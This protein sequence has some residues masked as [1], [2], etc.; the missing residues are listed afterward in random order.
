MCLE[1]LFSPE[2]LDGAIGLAEAMYVGVMEHVDPLHRPSLWE[3]IVL[4][5]GISQIKG[6]LARLESEI[7]VYISASETS[8][9]TQAKD[10][11]M[12]GI[13]EFF[14]EYKGAMVDAAFLGASMVA[15][16]V[17]VDARNYI[18]KGDYNEMGPGCVHMKSS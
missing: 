13:P 5:G 12:A 17:F 4:T 8:H 2:I 15:K 10:I 18:G 9:E 6:M 7:A 14:T 3:N 1:P 16:L 11:V